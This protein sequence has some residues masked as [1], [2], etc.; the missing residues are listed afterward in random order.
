MTNFFFGSRSLISFFSRTLKDHHFFG[1]EE[2]KTWKNQDY[3]FILKHKRKKNIYFFY[4][5][6]QKAVCRNVKLIIFFVGI[7]GNPDLN[8]RKKT[9]VEIS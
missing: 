3:N 4:F 5:T 1:K 2:K 8:C 9:S 7:T 6:K